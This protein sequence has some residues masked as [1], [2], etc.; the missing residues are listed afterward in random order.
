MASGVVLVTGASD[1]IGE[2][3]AF[4][5]RELDKLIGRALGG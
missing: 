4:H 2:A 3:T 5:L 1:R